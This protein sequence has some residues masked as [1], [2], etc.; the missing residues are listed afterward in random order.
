SQP[1]YVAAASPQAGETG[2]ALGMS[3][4]RLPIPIPKFY[5]VPKPPRTQ[6]VQVQSQP[7]YTQPV[8]SQP[9]YM[10]PGQYSPPPVAY[11]PPVQASPPAPSSCQTDNE[12]LLSMM[13]AL[14]QQQEQQGRSPA[15]SASPPPAPAANQADLE[16]RTKALSDKLDRLTEAVKRGE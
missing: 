4:V 8:Y 10:N 7:V 16:A 15:A 3:V 13:M 2:I 9:V 6:L 5:A 1:Q 12:Q 11:S 14:Q